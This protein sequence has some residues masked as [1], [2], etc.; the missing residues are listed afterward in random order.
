MTACSGLSSEISAVRQLQWSRDQRRAETARGRRCGSVRRALPRLQS[1]CLPRSHS[2]WFLVVPC[3]C[4]PGL[5]WT[6]LMRGHP[7]M[8]RVWSNTQHPTTGTSDQTS[9]ASGHRESGA[10]GIHTR[11]HGNC[12]RRAQAIGMAQ[13]RAGNP[14]CGKRAM[15]AGVIG[16][17]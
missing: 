5:G 4:L 3:A 8:A 16:G 13:A 17:S 14:G 9:W 1:R 6:C 2:L 11:S 10:H 12:R 15:R 7:R